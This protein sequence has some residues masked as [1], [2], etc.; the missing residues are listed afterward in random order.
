MASS[1]SNRFGR[2]LSPTLGRFLLVGVSNTALSY[3]VFRLCLRLWSTGLYSATVAQLIAYAAGIVW[4][5]SWNR[6]W[7]FRSRGPVARDA[8]RF[9]LLQVVVLL[10]SAGLIGL[11]VDRLKYPATPSWLAVTVLTTAAN[12]LGARFLVFTRAESS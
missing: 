9:L 12:F 1:V 3:G 8:V 6:R 5:F 10:A 7:T 4:S 2:L 11:A